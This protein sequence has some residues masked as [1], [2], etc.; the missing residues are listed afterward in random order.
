LATRAA[1]HRSPLVMRCIKDF[2]RGQRFPLDTI[3]THLNVTVSA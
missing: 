3:Y 1:E 2:L